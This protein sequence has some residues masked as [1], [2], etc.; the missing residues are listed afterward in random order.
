LEQYVYFETFIDN[1]TLFLFLLVMQE[2]EL[3]A[4]V[5]ERGRQE[6]RQRRLR[7][8]TSSPSD[9][10]MM[11][12]G[13]DCSSSRSSGLLKEDAAGHDTRKG[14]TFP[15]RKNEG[16]EHR[17]QSMSQKSGGSESSTRE[18]L[19]AAAR[20]SLRTKFDH[21]GIDPH[22][23]SAIPDRGMNN[24]PPPPSLAMAVAASNMA[25]FARQHHPEHGAEHSSIARVHSPIIFSP[26][27][28][29]FQLHQAAA[30]A[31]VHIGGTS[32]TLDLETMD[33]G[34]GANARSHGN[35]GGTESPDPEVRLLLVYTFFA[36][37][38]MES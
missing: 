14:N 16:D 38:E 6:L 21:V 9:D 23:S 26:G 15:D 8:R 37:E 12:S 5:G 34:S 20:A 18:M 29:L 3:A 4:L 25:G 13:N 17:Q 33:E 11:E 35:L 1:Q 27:S 24:S 10:I 22:H 7:R 2:R 19:E 36:Q 31:G 30:L 28:H 32:S